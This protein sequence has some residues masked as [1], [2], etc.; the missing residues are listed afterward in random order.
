LNGDVYLRADG[1]GVT[2]FDDGARDSL[3]GLTGSDW[4]FADFDGAETNRRDLI[5]ALASGEARE[6]VD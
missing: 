6:D 5:L 1:P 3:A 2:V 4:F